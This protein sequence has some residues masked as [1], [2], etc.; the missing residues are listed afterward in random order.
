[1]PGGKSVIDLM[2]ASQSWKKNGNDGTGDWGRNNPKK[3]NH[4]FKDKKPPPPSRRIKRVD[5]EK[6]E[7][8]L[9]S[10][11]TGQYERHDPQV[12]YKPFHV[13]SE[14]NALH[15]SAQQRFARRNLAVIDRQRAK[16]REE[17]K[18]ANLRVSVAQRDAN[19]W[20]EMENHYH[21]NQTK[22][23]ND[24]VT[25]ARCKK[26]TTGKAINLFTLG[27]QDNAAGDRLRQSDNVVIERASRRSENLFNRRNGSHNPITGEPQSFP[28]T[29]GRGW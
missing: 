23:A 26:N 1:M 11:R 20:G 2:R 22:I 6:I 13:V 28:K 4:Q 8:D 18:V 10:L 19:R 24:R 16:A 5:R 29:N 25:G 9:L 15:A 14:N 3:T 27:Y 12:I 17:A 21:K 7:K